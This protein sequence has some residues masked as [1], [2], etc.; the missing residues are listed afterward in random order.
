MPGKDEL[1][2]WKAIFELLVQRVQKPVLVVFKGKNC[3]ILGASSGFKRI[4]CSLLHYL[5]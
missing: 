3:H 5:I 2:G 1:G 4:A